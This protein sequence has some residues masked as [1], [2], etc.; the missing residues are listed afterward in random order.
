MSGSLT[1]RLL[2]RAGSEA[3]GGL[4][5]GKVRG[6]GC[7]SKTLGRG[8]AGGADDPARPIVPSPNACGLQRSQ[9]QSPAGRPRLLQCPLAG[10]EVPLG[11]PAEQLG[12]C[13]CPAARTQVQDARSERRRGQAPEDGGV[14]CPPVTRGEWERH[15][16][17]SKIH[18]KSWTSGAP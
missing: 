5:F 4:R 6:M 3:R 16:S 15:G 1:W 9:S 2:S 14:W 12:G 8:G 17:W 7:G 18:F 11:F 10:S 13:V